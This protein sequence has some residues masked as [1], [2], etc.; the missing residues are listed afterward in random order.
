MDGQ[1]GVHVNQSGNE[2]APTSID[3]VYLNFFLFRFALFIDDVN[4]VLA[5]SIVDRELLHFTA[6]FVNLIGTRARDVLFNPPNQVTNDE[7]IMVLLKTVA[8]PIPNVDVLDE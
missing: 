1:V 2:K 7:Y 4:G 8:F 3:Y 6:L 5:D